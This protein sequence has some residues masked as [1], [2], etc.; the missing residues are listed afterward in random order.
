MLEHTDYAE[1]FREP[2]PNEYTSPVDEYPELLVH[3][4]QGCQ[5]VLRQMRI[6]VTDCYNFSQGKETLDHT[7][8]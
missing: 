4:F 3:E 2:V 7:Y 6:K 8:I 1:V 5:C